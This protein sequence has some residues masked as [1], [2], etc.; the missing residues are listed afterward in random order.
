[1]AKDVIIRPG[2]GKIQ[3]SGDTL[4]GSPEDGT[5]EFSETGPDGAGLYFTIGSVRKKILFE[6]EGPTGPT[7]PTGSQGS[8]GSQGSIGSTG[9]IGSSGPTGPTGSVGS[10]G[11]TGPTGH[12]G[13]IGSSGPTGPTGSVGSSGPTGPTGSSG[14][15]G[16]IGVIGS[17]GPQ[18]V[19]G[20]VGSTGPTGP[21]GGTGPTGPTGP[22]GYTTFPIRGP[23]GSI[24][25]TGPSGPQGYSGD[26]GPSAGVENYVD[27][28]TVSGNWVCPAGVT[29][30]TVYCIGAGGGGGTTTAPASYIGGGAG[31]SS[32]TKTLAVI[33]G[34]SYFCSIGAGSTT[35]GGDTYFVN[36]S[37]CLAKGGAYS[38]SSSGAAGSSTGCVGDSV[39]SGGDGGNATMSYSGGGGGGAG[40]NISGG[41]ASGA[42]AGAG[43]YYGGYGGSGVSVS[44]TRNDGNTYGGGGSG[45][46]EIAS[47]P[48]IT[49]TA[50]SSI[51][52]KSAVSGGD[53]SCS[54]S[55]DQRGVVW[56]KNTNPTV[57][58]VFEG[59]TDNGSGTGTFVSNITTN[60]KNTTY[61]I[62]AYA[63]VGST[64]YYGN[65]VSFVTDNPT[66]YSI[67]FGASTTCS[68]GTITCTDETTT[69]N[70]SWQYINCCLSCVRGKSAYLVYSVSA[71]FP[72]PGDILYND[73]CKWTATRWGFYDDGTTWWIIYLVNGVVST[74]YAL[75]S[76]PP[77]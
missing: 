4:I 56:S 61:Y 17:T 24:G 75:S 60:C 2:D 49:T 50:A 25:P 28:I 66:T 46:Y 35:T 43:F 16:A 47:T 13:S 32:A 76:S 70:A 3:F 9:P 74:R 18:G 33:P 38:T 73:D 14:P 37:T 41:N 26:T 48:T 21:Q 59:Y 31:G 69:V 52:Y 45:A 36:T 40:Q 54:C 6:A 55:I 12:Q 10:S 44:N 64:Y 42:Y 19:T 8:L 23:Q 15:S 11:P 34:N 65:Q 1:M 62:R 72:L 68:G 22:T 39:W 20:G 71:S 27:V 77:L 67:F 5:L 7:G 51:T 63:L 58:G 30:V 57:D 29:S 53:I